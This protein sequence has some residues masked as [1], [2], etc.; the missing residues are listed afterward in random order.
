MLPGSHL[1][2]DI[3]SRTVSRY[4]ENW[5]SGKQVECPA[6][7]VHFSGS[8]DKV[9]ASISY[10][11][12]ENIFLQRALAPGDIF[13]FNQSAVHGLS[14]RVN[15]NF[16]LAISVVPSPV[17]ASI[18]GLKRKQ[19]LKRIVANIATSSAC[20]YQL[21]KRKGIDPGECLFDGYKFG[22]DDMRMLTREG[23]WHDLFG[24]R[25]IE[26]EVWRQAFD[27]AKSTC[28]EHLQNHL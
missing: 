17:S 8:T 22:E 13:I 4:S 5:S 23:E 24:L 19:H 11:Q 3:Y 1:P 18:F 28:W 21:A 26:K 27:S 6:G 16:F 2:G 25:F 10:L 14:A 15:R 9:V 12:P 20:E 7:E